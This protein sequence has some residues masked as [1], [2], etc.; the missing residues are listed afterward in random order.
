MSGRARQ[1]IDV[2]GRRADDPWPV[3][4][5]VAGNTDAL[6]TRYRSGRELV[7]EEKHLVGGEG[8]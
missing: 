8:K 5:Q 7:G 2:I 1:V 4:E 3:A 6:Q